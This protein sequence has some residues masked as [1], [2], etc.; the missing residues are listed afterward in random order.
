MAKPRL[1]VTGE[2]ALIGTI[3]GKSFANDP[4]NQWV[5]GDE[6]AI[7]AYFTLVAKK[8]YI[9]SGFGHVMEDASGGTLWLTPQGAKHISLW[10]SLEIGTSL[11][12]HGGMRSITR[13]IALDNYLIARMPAEPHYYLYAIGA[14]PARQGKGIG[15]QLMAAGLA[16]ADADRMP[17]YLESSKE[18]NVSFYR[19]FGFE[20]TAVAE[21]PRGCPPLWLM[22]REPR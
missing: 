14:D 11:I 19:R 20:V 5:F 13:G 18:S 15:G 2:H 12:R 16:R 22:W 9:K 17:A 7:R 3:I 8:L 10:D 21:P 6:Q 1:L 4:V